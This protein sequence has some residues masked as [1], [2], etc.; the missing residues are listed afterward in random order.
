MV[1]APELIELGRSGGAVPRR[2]M[3]RD[4]EIPWQAGSAVPLPPEEARRART[5]P[6][7]HVPLVQESRGGREIPSFLIR[8]RR[9]LGLMPRRSAAPPSPST[10]Q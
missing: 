3:S 6:R 9:V 10:F 4:R 2:E 1:G 5:D 7:N 8:E